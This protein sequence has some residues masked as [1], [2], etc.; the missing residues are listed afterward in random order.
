VSY[1]F[2]PLV[3]PILLLRALPYR[4]SRSPAQPE[5]TREAAFRDH[6]P[7]LAPRAVG[8]LLALE[9]ALLRQ[10]IAIPFGSSCLAVARKA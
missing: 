3:L 10:G 7:G 4:F 5:A 9:L 6:A 8:T 1:F 2:V